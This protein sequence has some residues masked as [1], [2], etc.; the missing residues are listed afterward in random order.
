MATRIQ[1]R[2]GTAAEWESE[3]PILAL[4]EIGFDTT[5]ENIRI[6]DGVSAWNDL[7]SV[8][9]PPGPEGP[10]GPTG[11][12][13]PQGVTGPTGPTGPL[14]RTTFYVSPTA[15]TNPINGDS[16]FNSETA[17]TAVYYEDIDSS[18]WIEAGNSGPTG[19]TGP[20]GAT[21]PQGEPGGEATVSTSPPSSPVP[22]QIWL[23][24][25]EGRTYV[26]YLFNLQGQWI[27]IL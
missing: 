25:D 17:V 22:G 8:S 7:D 11:P 23:D 27:E 24:A 2:R 14:G 12:T 10:Q 13:G 15:P 4:G 19:P 18:Q 9:G 20:I 6:G 21:G 26:W 3:N 1:Q 5:N 16:W